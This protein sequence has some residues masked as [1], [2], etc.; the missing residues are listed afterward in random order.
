[1]KASTA[2]VLPVTTAMSP[3]PASRPQAV[4]GLVGEAVRGTAGRAGLPAGRQESSH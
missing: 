2:L 4:A 3:F 1:M